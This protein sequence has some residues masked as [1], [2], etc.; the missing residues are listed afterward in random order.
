MPWAMAQK[1]RAA[2][3]CAAPGFLIQSES[4]FPAKIEGLG[5][6]IC[7]ETKAFFGGADRSDPEAG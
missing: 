1:T 2:Q 7:R 3:K 6:E 5:R 4:A